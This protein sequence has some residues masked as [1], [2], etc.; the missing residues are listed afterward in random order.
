M[1]PVMDGLELCKC[2]KT[3]EK[4]SHIPIILLTARATLESKI[5][6]LET[7]ADD[8]ITKPF[9]IRELTVRIKNLIEQ[10][11]HIQQ[12]FKKLAGLKPEEIATSSRDE[13]FLKKAL[14][15]LEDHITDSDFNV[16]EF[17]KAIAISSSHLNRKIKALTGQSTQQF[18]LAFRLNRAAQLLENDSGTILE[19]ATLVGIESVSYFS[20]TF[21]KQFGV[22]PSQYRN[23]NSF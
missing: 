21:R 6:G 15:I 8:Y 3:D 7:G 2:I 13:E 22:S 19:I 14:S 18:I 16:S 17:S 9:D 10:R 1:M 5:E 20:R 23:N 11:N 12:H 4:T